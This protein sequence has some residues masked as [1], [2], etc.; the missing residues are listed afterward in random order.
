MAEAELAQASA[1]LAAYLNVPASSGSFDVAAGEAPFTIPTIPTPRI[2]SYD[3]AGVLANASFTAGLSLRP[4]V[5]AARERETAAAAAIRT[6]QRMLFREA[7][8]TLGVKQMVGTNS[9]V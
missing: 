9:M 7:G 2:A 1:Q 4:D 3:T 6:E 5:R 8:L